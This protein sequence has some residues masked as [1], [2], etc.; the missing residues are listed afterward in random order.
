M[1]TTVAC[2][3][4]I[5]VFIMVKNVLVTLKLI[6][7]RVLLCIEFPQKTISAIEDREEGKHLHLLKL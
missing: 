6:R 3:L 7:D 2:I 1:E 5:A 4:I